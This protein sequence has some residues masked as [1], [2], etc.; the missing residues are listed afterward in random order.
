MSQSNAIVRYIA[1]NYKG[2]KGETLYPSVKDGDIMLMHRIDEVLEEASAFFISYIN[3]VTE[4]F[5]GYKNRDAVIPR[6]LEDTLPKT[7]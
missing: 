7:L 6:W 5:P 3:L 1:K 4:I 2:L